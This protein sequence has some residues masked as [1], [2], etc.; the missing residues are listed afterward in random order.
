MKYSSDS[1]RTL[2]DLAKLLAGSPAPV[3]LLEGSRALPAELYPALTAL[4]RLLAARLPSVRFRSGNAVGTA[5]AFAEG[6]AAVAPERLEYVITNGGMGRK[7]RIAGCRVVTLDD[8]SP[9]AAER[10]IDL[11]RTAASAARVIEAYRTYGSKN[12]VGSKG[13][14]LVR[15]TLKVVGDPANDLA[16][17]TAA[18]FYVRDA[19]PLSGGTGP[20]IRVCQNHNVPVIPQ[21]VWLNWR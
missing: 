19:S 17:A 12:V 5:T 10:I 9:E 16:P 20:T 8:L 14:Y 18:L 7:R 13:A 21:T 1:I 4:G 3:V 15:D 11:S 2:A 6:V